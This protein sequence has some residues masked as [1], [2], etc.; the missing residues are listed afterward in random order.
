MD[1][2]ASAGYSVH[3]YDAIEWL[4]VNASRLKHYFL[5]YRYKYFTLILTFFAYTTYH[6]SRKPIGVVK[7]RFILY[8]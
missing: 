7:V 1:M 8:T 6:L 3:V 5:L 2:F 4:I